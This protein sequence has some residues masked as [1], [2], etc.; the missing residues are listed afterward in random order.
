MIID[1]CYIC[2][3]KGTTGWFIF[4]DMCRFCKGTGHIIEFDEF[5][6][7]KHTV[8]R[9][10]KVLTGIKVRHNREDEHLSSLHP[11]NFM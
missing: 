5:H 4:K 8:N 2:K 11:D 10:K 9:M 7:V 6:E 1:H 3:G